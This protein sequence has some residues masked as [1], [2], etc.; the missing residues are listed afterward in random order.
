MTEHPTTNVGE[1]LVLSSRIS[2][3]ARV[4]GW[5]EQLA[6]RYAIP[7]NIQFAMNLCLEEALSNC[8]RHGYAEETGHPMTVRFTM[9]KRGQLVLTVEDE[10]PHFNPLTAPG[11][12]PLKPDGDIS[13][14]GQGLRLIR[15]FSD[16]LEYEATPVGNR[17]TMMFSISE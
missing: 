8:V 7:P 10:A 4:P 1:G 17:L 13:V 12:S 16:K 6:L 3:I 11:E 9:P 14:G 15:Q 5:I 2:E